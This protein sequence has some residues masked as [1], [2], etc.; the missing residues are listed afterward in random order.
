[1]RHSNEMWEFEPTPLGITIY[2][3]VTAMFFSVTHEQA[4][5]LLNGLDVA[6]N[7][8][9]SSVPFNASSAP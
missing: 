9:P 2:S 7:S 5:M 4:E 1:M 8:Q 3:R 6:L